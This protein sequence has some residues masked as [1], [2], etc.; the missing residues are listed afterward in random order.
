MFCWY[1]A[2]DPPCRPCAGW[3]ADLERKPMSTNPIATTVSV[4]TLL[5]AG[6]AE[7]ASQP[8]DGGPA[9]RQF[10]GMPLIFDEDFEQ[11]VP[12]LW[13]PTDPKAWKFT[14]DGG[15]GVYALATPSA[16]RAKVR[17]PNGIAWRKGLYF[18]DFVMDAR[19]R[20]TTKNYGHRDMCLFFG[21]QSPTRFHYVHMGLQSDDH[22]NSIF[23]VN[24]QPR[25]SIA[26][27]RN[28][29]TAWSEGYH[30]VRVVRRVKTGSIEVFFDDMN[31]PI[32]TAE[33]KTF[34]WGRVGI[35]SFDDTGVIDRVTV[36]GVELPPSAT[37]PVNP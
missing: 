1:D 4:M 36:W 34:T 7:P 37:Q 24:D 29:G 17:S 22:S 26:K 19:L 3:T 20:S 28:K 15:R 13:E 27:T 8:A 10:M 30:H 35:G 11:P 32:M 33:D 18:G 6:G 31:T 21:G 9:P 2:A 23:I 16:Y 12:D 14:R 25:T 5:V